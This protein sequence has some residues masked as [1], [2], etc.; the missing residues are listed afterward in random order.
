MPWLGSTTL[1]EI[2]F[3]LGQRHGLPDSGRAWMQILEE[4]R[5]RTLPLADWNPNEP[6]SERLAP[7]PA[8]PPAA[9][10]PAGASWVETV[11][12]LGAR[13]ADGLAHAHEQGILHRDIRPAHVLSS[14]GQP[15]LFGFEVSE[16]LQDHQT[17]AGKI[18]D[19]RALGYQAPEQLAALVGLP[20]PVAPARGGVFPA[21][22]DARSDL[23]ALGVLLFELLTRRHPFAVQ[24]GPA[25]QVIPAMIQERLAPPPVVRPWNPDVSPA[26]ESIIRHCLEPDPARRY[27]TAAH[28]RE[29]LIRH[30]EH[31]PLAYAAEPSQEERLGKWVARHTTLTVCAGAAVLAGFLGLALFTACLGRTHGQARQEAIQ[32]LAEFRQDLQAIR[33]L[34]YSSNDPAARDEGQG[35]ARQALR[36]YGLLP[37]GAAAREDEAPGEAWKSALQRPGREPPVYHYLSAQE[38]GQLD[39]ELGE[40]LLLL[41][42]WAR[43][44]DAQEALC[45]NELAEVCYPAEAAP[46]SLWSQRARLLRWLGREREAEAARQRA[47]ATPVRDHLDHFLE[48]RRAADEGDQAEA[49]RLAR[50]MV[51]QDPAS[52]AARL[53]LGDCALACFPDEAPQ[54]REAIGHYSICIVLQPDLAWAWFNRAR[55]HLRCHDPANA[56]ADLS[57]ALEL[58]PAL[59]EAW[60]LRA[61]ARAELSRG[62]ETQADL[63]QA[64]RDGPPSLCLLLQRSRLRQQ[65][66]DSAGARRDR[67]AALRLP[68]VEERDWIARG[69]HHLRHDPQAALA[70]FTEAVRLEPD[71]LEGVLE[72]ARVLADHLNQPH[73]ALANLDRLLYVRPHLTRARMQRALLHGR[74]GQRL[75]AHGDARVIL[76]R[77]PASGQNLLLAARVYALT[78]RTHPADRDEAFRLLARA[79]QIGHGHEQMAADPDLAPLRSDPRFPSLVTAVCTLR[80]CAARS[81]AGSPGE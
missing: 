41:G 12:W 65:L 4:H 59:R 24:S 54:A 29:D 7:P 14:E 77:N 53:L 73:Q 32:C 47:A 28:L 43:R 10:V 69:R 35:R 20:A 66:G 37:G 75:Q 52:W 19:G 74:L 6:A 25:P 79:L 56:E 60:I 48:A 39:A 3:D 38:Q 16:D 22:V 64:L 2:L 50:E 40:V 17:L 81:Q 67:E 13:L 45:L 55:A 34:A 26:V 44:A 68:P 9:S 33:F 8:A 78:S 15:M 80:E 18:P 57:R 72:Q 63:D 23:Y 49:Q 21:E 61:R 70:D 27:Q 46:R 11:L 30:L 36:R 58:R 1:A 31:Q 5:G 51:D 42:A 76:A 71:S 62:K